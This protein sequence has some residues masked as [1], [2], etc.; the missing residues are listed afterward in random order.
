MN[1]ML[2]AILITAGSLGLLVAIGRLTDN[3][4]GNQAERWAETLANKR[5]EP[6]RRR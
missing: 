3:L 1:H 6:E 4:L 2:L 5:D